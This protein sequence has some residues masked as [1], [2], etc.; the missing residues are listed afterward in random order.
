MRSVG[1]KE[2]DS[3]QTAWTGDHF[4]TGVES[5]VKLLLRVWRHL[6]NNLRIFH[7]SI[8]I[9]TIEAYAANVDRNQQRPMAIR[10]NFF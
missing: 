10:A 1:S 3:Q 5:R 8:I 9:K 6:L 7:R 4:F 2:Q